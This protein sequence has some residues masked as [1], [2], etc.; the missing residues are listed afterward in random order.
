MVFTIYGHGGHLR[1]K[2][3]NKVLD[4]QALLHLSK[5]SCIYD[6][7]SV[8]SFFQPTKIM[9]LDFTPLSENHF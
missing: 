8:V 4:S 9:T 3:N 7:F 6:F 2:K 1:P 5:R